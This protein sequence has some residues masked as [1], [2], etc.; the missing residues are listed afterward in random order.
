MEVS[1]CVAVFVVG[2]CGRSGGRRVRSEFFRPVCSQ[3]RVVSQ[4]PAAQTG[5]ELP[6]GA[7]A[8][9]LVSHKSSTTKTK[10]R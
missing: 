10:L 7:P 5:E 8:L 3:H 4:R 2:V 9:R 6:L 1:L